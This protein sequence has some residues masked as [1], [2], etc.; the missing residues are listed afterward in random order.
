M[1][2]A[3]I[4]LAAGEGTRMK[5]DLPKVLHT[6]AGLP[7]LVH[8]LSVC[9]ELKPE[10]QIVVLGHQ[11]EQVLAAIGAD[12]DYVHQKEQNGTG[13]A[14]LVTEER[15]KDFDGAVL[16]LAGDIP[17][18]QA[19]TL[20]NLIDVFIEDKPAAALVTAELENPFGYGR[21]IRDRAG[22]VARIVEQND[23]TSEE[24][25]VKEINAG[26]YCFDS[27]RLFSALGL[28]G[29]HNKKSEYYLTDVISVLRNQGEVVLASGASPDEVLG[30][31]TRSELADAESIIQARLRRIFMEAGVTFINPETS[32][33]EATVDI[34]RD[35]SILPNCFIQGTTKIGKGSKIGPNARI[36][37]SS[38]GEN[39]NVQYS[40]INSANVEDEVDIGPFCYIR[41]GTRLMRGSKAG[42]FVEIKKSEI[43]PGSKVPHLSY[44]G[45]AVIGEDVNV[46]AGSITCNYD[47]VEKHETIIEDG[48]FL[49]SDTMLIAPVKIGR[50]AVTGAGSSITE[51]V[52]PDSLSV[53]RAEQKTVPDWAKQRRSKT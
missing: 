32:Y 40:V 15:M 21:I 45:D 29:N 28:I 13:H 26:I 7:M 4:V 48:A 22:T 11:H 9:K 14:V 43:G 46:G 2:L 10:R 3:T 18:L 34:E 35:T 36:I 8:V 1:K 19:E 12:V 30:V 47:G 23:A 16:V 51:D 24:R 5:S 44:M 41:P 31:N 49:G 52:P 39:A 6:L 17:L 53:E 42:T 38:I 33:L 20:K 25:G 50:G 37:D 27:R